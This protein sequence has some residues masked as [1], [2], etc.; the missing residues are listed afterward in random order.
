MFESAI[1]M[2][3]DV[4]VTKIV[5]VAIAAEEEG[6]DYILVPDEGVTRDVFVALTAIALNTKRI[7]F[8]PAI[9]NP[10]TR[11]PVVSA[12]AV[13]T[14][15]ELSEGRAFLGY[16]IGGSLIL[17]PMGYD[18]ERPLKGMRGTIEISRRFYDGGTVNYGGD[19]ITA[20]DAGVK[21]DVRGIPI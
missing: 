3:T 17:G 20:R 4:P 8:G 16:G 7:K 12:V 1:W 18:I 2:P 11:H 13:A 5:D 19:Y 9:V 10:Y 21:V 14:L 6:F 15:D